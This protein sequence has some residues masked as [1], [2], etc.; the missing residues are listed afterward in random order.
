L[1]AMMFSSVQVGALELKNR[2]VR[3]AT[4]DGMADR[5]G[6]VSEG[7]LALYEALATG[8]AGLIVTGLFSVHPSGR[9]SGYQNIVSDDS[10][11]EGLRELAATVHRHG[12][13]IL[14]Q[15]AHCGRE[16]HL[17]QTYKGQTAVAPSLLTA[18][19]YFQHPHR[20]LS[21]EEIVEIVNA[22]GA[23]AGRA[24]RA[25]FDGVQLHGAHAYLVSQFLSPHTN[26]RS[27]GWGGSAEA[28]FRLVEKIYT[29]M[30]RRVGPDY[31][32]HIKLG[33][34][35]GFEG[36]LAFEEGKAA[37]QRC[38][39]LGFASVEV[40]QGL[41]GKYYR[42]TEFRTG[43]PAR[44]PEAYF[45]RWARSI[46]ELTGA[47]VVMVG[48]L[49]S[50]EVVREVLEG[51]ETDLVALCRPL[52]REPDLIARWRSGDRRPSR[53]VSC[54]RCFEILF[55]GLPLRCVAQAARAT[56]SRLQS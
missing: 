41:R 40:S 21:E 17:Y 26:R 16:A 39:D 53:C 18:D 11:A 43:V 29:A 27:D 22:F 28:R 52:I 9:I 23:A 14:M 13:K 47:A 3:S 44:T 55:K 50:I 42:Q 8:G 46:R 30:R 1:I 10:T 2:F 37:A 54:N 45:R 38:V 15:V 4:Y 51:G 25:G 20:A 7:Q 56:E 33:V 32:I 35:D 48:G 34:A 6:R 31:P 36:G 12:A 5:R 24:Q 19:P 49:R